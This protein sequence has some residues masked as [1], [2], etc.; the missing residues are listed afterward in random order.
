M[1]HMGTNSVI[2]G[3]EGVN[4]F[5]VQYMMIEKQHF[6]SLYIQKGLIQ[7]KRVPNFVEH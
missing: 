3:L 4:P 5:I 7:F 1:G 2:M 6:G